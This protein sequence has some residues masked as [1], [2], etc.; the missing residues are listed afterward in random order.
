MPGPLHVAPSFSPGA[1]AVPATHLPRLS[2]PSVEVVVE[3]DVLV[4]RAARA[5]EVEHAAGQRRVVQYLILP[6]SAATAIAFA[7]HDVVPLVRP[8]SRADRRSRRVYGDR[9]RRREHEPRWARSAAEAPRRKSLPKPGWRRMTPRAV[10]RR[11]IGALGFAL[12][13]QDVTSLPGGPSYALD[14]VPRR[15][16]RR[17]RQAGARGGRRSGSIR[18]RSGSTAR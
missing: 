10:V 11:R 12:E 2:L 9:A 13:G 3:V 14:R 4:R 6:A 8:P 15:E 1:Y 16:D 18:R 7:G 17:M 5:V